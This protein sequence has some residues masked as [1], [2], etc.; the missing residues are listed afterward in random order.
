MEARFRR[1]AWLVAVTSFVGFMAAAGWSY[2]Q[3]QS[4]QRTVHKLFDIMEKSISECEKDRASI[5]CESIQEKREVFHSAA[6]DRDRYSQQVGQ[7][8]TAAFVLPIMAIVLFIAL[9]WVVTGKRPQWPLRK[10]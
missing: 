10:S 6:E 8:L 2:Y 3:E 4:M 9:R 7:Y 1:L 5:Y